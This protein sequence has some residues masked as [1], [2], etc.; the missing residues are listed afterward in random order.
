MHSTFGIKWFRLV[1]AEWTVIWNVQPLRYLKRNSFGTFY[2]QNIFRKCFSITPQS[3]HLC[4]YICS[5]CRNEREGVSN[6]RRPCCLLNRFF[7]GADQR[8]MKSRIHRWPVNSP[9]KG[10]VTRKMFPSDDGITL[11]VESPAASSNARYGTIPSIIFRAYR[12][13]FAACLQN[14]C[15]YVTYNLMD[16]VSVFIYIIILIRFVYFYWPHSP[17]LVS[18]EL[19]MQ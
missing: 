13:A 8:S 18:W 11:F 14:K 9:H 4:G 3:R 5:A 12:D 15:W 16:F 19:L 7:S 1:G 17:V 6:H 10:P 2:F